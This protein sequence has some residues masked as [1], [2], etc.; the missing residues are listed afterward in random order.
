MYLSWGLEMLKIK[1]KEL[2][3]LMGTTPGYTQILLF[4]KKLKL[5]NKYL[6]AIIDLIVERRRK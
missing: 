1:H 5:N 3:R 4:R 6:D 2:A